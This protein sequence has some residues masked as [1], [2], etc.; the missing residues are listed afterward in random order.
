MRRT[1]IRPDDSL[2]FGEIGVHKNF[3]TLNTRK[4]DDKG[5]SPRS[6]ILEICIFILVSLH[7]RCGH[8]S[9]YRYFFFFYVIGIFWFHFFGQSILEESFFFCILVWWRAWRVRPVLNCASA[10]PSLMDAA[11]ICLNVC[12]IAQDGVGRLLQKNFFVLDI[13]KL[14]SVV[15]ILHEVFVRIDVAQQYLFRF[16]CV[17]YCVKS[18]DANLF[19]LVWNIFFFVNESRTIDML[20]FLQ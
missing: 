19:R 5:K 11:F 15:A 8:V 13:Q 2:I 16:E 12:Q 14:W 9:V 4:G 6:K 1:L 7:E 18:C 17:I 3:P 10:Y 20:K